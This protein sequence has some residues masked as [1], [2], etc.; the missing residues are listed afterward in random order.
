MSD[1]HKDFKISQQAV[2]R[3]S[4]GEILI[5]REPHMDHWLLPGGRIEPSDENPVEAFRREVREE[6]GCEIVIGSPLAT[7]VSRTGNTYAIAFLCEVDDADAITL[8][9]EHSESKWVAPSE[10]NKYL[11]YGNIA[12]AIAEALA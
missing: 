2:I 1:H 9:A 4:A 5:L 6:I 12:S 3:N 8:S 7:D 11:Y 10:V